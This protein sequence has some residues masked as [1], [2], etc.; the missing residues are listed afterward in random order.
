MSGSQQT[1]EKEER[2]RKIVIQRLDLAI[3]DLKKNKHFKE[4][5]KLEDFKSNFLM[6]PDGTVAYRKSMEEEK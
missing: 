6:L 1:V 4:A 3:A 5:K 2:I